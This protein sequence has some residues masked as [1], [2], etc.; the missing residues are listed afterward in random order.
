MLNR[1]LFLLLLAAFT[2]V[3]QAQYGTPS[4]PQTR[5]PQ[6]SL[7]S[8]CPWLTQGTAAWALGGDVSATVNMSTSAEGSCKF[9]RLQGPPDS[10][11]I[12]VRKTALPACPA[13]S[14]EL[15]G[16]G[17]QATRCS[18][19][20]SHGEDVEMISSR[21]RDLYFTVTL[22]SRG[23]RSA[24]KPDRQNDALEQISEEIAGNLY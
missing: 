16:I 19:P 17:N 6:N 22:A 18:C 20:A 14:L 5:S 12:V 24:S 4:A 9:S 15:K 13:A 7:K 11:E 10:V 1:R 21:V 3:T 2:A 23:Q 8:S